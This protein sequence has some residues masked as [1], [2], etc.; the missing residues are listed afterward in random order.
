MS[1][2]DVD[3]TGHWTG[4]YNYPDGPPVPFEAQLRESSGCV[5][6]TTTETSDLVAGHGQTLHAVI[7]GRRKGGSIR[8]L[9]MYDEAEGGYDVVHYDG[10]L[11]AD[12]NEIEGQWQIAGI[13]S[14][15]FLMIRATGTGRRLAETEEPLEIL[16]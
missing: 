5:T 6:G 9:K 10:A 2:K 4:L 12:G 1:R 15:T 7:D 13:W 16:R 14:G 3:L 8:F 11:H